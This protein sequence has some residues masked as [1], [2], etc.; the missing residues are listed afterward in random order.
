MW[1][2]AKNDGKSN[3]RRKYNKKNKI[4][5]LQ[6]NKG[7][8]YIF[9]R[10]STNSFTSSSMVSQLVTKRISFSFSSQI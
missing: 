2:T 6:P 10:I 9:K 8:N 3:R 5:K 7:H 1:N 4:G